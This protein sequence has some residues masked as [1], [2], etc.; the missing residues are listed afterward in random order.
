MQGFEGLAI[1][2]VN[3]VF[4][5]SSWASD[6]AIVAGRFGGQ[7]IQKNSA[8]SS[9]GLRIYFTDFGF[10]VGSEIIVGLAI[11]SNGGTQPGGIRCIA[12]G[13]YTEA[14]GVYWTKTEIRSRQWNSYQP[15][16][17]YPITQGTWYYVEWR[18]KMADSGG[19]HQIIVNGTDEIVDYTGDT[20]YSTANSMVG[21]YVYNQAYSACKVDDMY[22]I[23][24]DAVGLTDFLGDCRVDTIF[25]NGD[26]NYSQLTPSVG[27]NYECVDE[28]P[29]ETADYVEGDTD[30]E[31]DTYTYENVNVDID[32]SNI[33]GVSVQ[34]VGQRTLSVGNID[35]RNMVRSGGSDYY[36]SQDWPCGENF[37]GYKQS[38]WEDDPDDSNPWTQAK[39]NA[40]EFGVELNKT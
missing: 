7:A 12:S 19:R 26:G 34:S 21:I 31:K 25:P 17:Y 20:K 15:S 5:S 27:D 33:Y 13:S 29:I 30:G 36:G 28:D 11:C 22:V 10:S 23:M 35:L 2:D 32:D 14:W 16:T 40:C 8:S 6:S 9:M 39:I 1:G 18:Y 24:N 38:I 3:K 4:H 37:L